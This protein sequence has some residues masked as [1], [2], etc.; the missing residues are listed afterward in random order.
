MKPYEFSEAEREVIERKKEIIRRM[1]TE[2]Q[3]KLERMTQK[4]Q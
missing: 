3:M 2:S 1:K 4:T